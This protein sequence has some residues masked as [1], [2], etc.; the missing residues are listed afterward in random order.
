MQ[1][2][3]KTFLSGSKRT[4]DWPDGPEG[5]PMKKMTPKKMTLSRETIGTLSDKEMKAILGG[6][7]PETTNSKVACC[8]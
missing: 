1:R 8:A 5:D 7:L 2:R 3:T 6:A 4:D